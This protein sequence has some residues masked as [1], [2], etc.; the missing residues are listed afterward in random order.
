ME[1]RGVTSDKQIILSALGKA[2]LLATSEQNFYD[3]LR[4]RSLELYSRNGK[5]VGI[6]MNRNFRFSTL[7]YSKETIIK[8]NHNLSKDYRLKELQRIGEKQKGQSRKR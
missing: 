1:L 4:D 6:K 8:L 5:I 2:Y 3:Q 7:G